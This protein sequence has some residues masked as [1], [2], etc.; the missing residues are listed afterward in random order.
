MSLSIPIRV[1]PLGIRTIPAVESRIAGLVSVGT[2]RSFYLNSAAVSWA[3]IVSSLVLR[4]IV[5]F[6]GFA[7][8]RL[9]QG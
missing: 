7:E 4:L 5:D 1:C 6:E 8:L 2:L 9:G 3:Y